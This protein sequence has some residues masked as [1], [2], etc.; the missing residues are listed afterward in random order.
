MRAEAVLDRADDGVDAET[1]CLLSDHRIAELLCEAKLLTM[2]CIQNLFASTAQGN[3]D[4]DIELIGAD[5][6]E[7]RVKVRQNPLQPAD[8]SVILMYHL[9]ADGRWFRLRRYNGNTH[10]HRNRIE[11][12]RLDFSF[13]VH[14]ATERYQARGLKEDW[15]AEEATAH[16]DAR[17]AIECL[18]RDCGFATAPDPQ[19]HLDGVV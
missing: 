8:F 4:A 5:G 17:T 6:D 13:H 3:H 10:Q 1:R 9:P 2:H 11:G 14:T 16:T 7:F 12:D 18:L 19:T 15:F